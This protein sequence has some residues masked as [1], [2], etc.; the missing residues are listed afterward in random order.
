VTRRF[1]WAA[2]VALAV[3]LGGAAHADARQCPADRPAQSISGVT[4]QPGERSQPPGIED[5][6][7]A[8]EDDGMKPAR[9]LVR[10]NEYEGPYFT[11]RVGGGL[12]YDYGT[13]SQDEA[14]KQQ[15]TLNEN[16]AFRDGRVTLKGAFRFRRAVTWSMGV[17]YDGPSGDWLFRETGVMI[18]V[19]EILGH[20]FI[21]RTKEGFSL[22]KVMVGYAGWT[23]ERAT[24]TDATIPI[25]AD[26]IKWL[27]YAPEKRLLWNVGF[28]GDWLSDGQSFSTY[29][30]QLSGRL[31]WVAISSDEGRRV[32]HVGVNARFGKPDDGVIRLRSR[33]E[34]F[35]APYFVDTESFDASSTRMTGVEAYYRPGP[36]LVGG[37]Y[38]LQKAHAPESGDPVFHGGDIAVIWLATGET[39]TYNT[40]GGFFNQV[41]PARTV[42]DGGPGAWEVVTR[43]SYI[44]LDDKAV[45]G[46]RFWRLTPMVNWHLSDH[47]RLEM[48][49]GYGSLNRFQV[50][51]KT[52]FFQS[53]LQL[54]M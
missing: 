51:G 18:A 36:L 25:L 23:L 47:A 1:E 45:T 4:S 19:P 3:L 41:S 50:A 30:N 6:I 9:R 40:R 26:G 28:Y 52:H 11:I 44:D 39:R 35:L 31:A 8:G 5:T 49:Y 43:F 34:A 21:G 20:I 33:P 22:N 15:F 48:A 38:F 12:L 32:A 29:S 16:N 27:G 17:M 46:G 13:Y 53:R 14:S 10:W 54:T 7:A 24:I 37:E 2:S 42:F